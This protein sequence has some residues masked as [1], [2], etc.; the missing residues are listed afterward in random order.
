M[1]LKA[2]TTKFE[3]GMNADIYR[4]E[5]SQMEDHRNQNWYPDY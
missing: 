2:D 3:D 5:N 1:G 4:I